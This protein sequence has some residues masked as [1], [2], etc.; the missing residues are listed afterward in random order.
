MSRSAAGGLIYLYGGDAPR[1]NGSDVFH[2]FRACSHFSYLTGVTEP[3]FGALLDPEDGSLTLLA[4]RVPDDA[5]VWWGGLPSLDD[6]A[7]AAGAQRAVYATDLPALLQERHMTGAS[8]GASNG[9]TSGGPT[10]HV[11]PHMTPDLLGAAMAAPGAPEHAL[12][13]LEALRRAADHGTTF[14]TAFLEPALSRARAHKTEA[15]IGCLLQAS[16]GSAAGHRAMWQAARHGIHEYQLEAAFVHATTQVRAPVSCHT[17]TH[18]CMFVSLSVEVWGRRG[19][20][21]GGCAQH[22]TPC[23]IHPVCL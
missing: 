10:L 11:L 22:T 2:P 1:R 16:R 21:Q 5:A 15:E 6:L 12:A 20:G 7:E 17:H 8:K 13:A 14:N 18:R 9:A 3:G 23:H 4:P 19:G